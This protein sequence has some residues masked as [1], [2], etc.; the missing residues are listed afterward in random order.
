MMHARFGTT[1]FATPAQIVEREVQPL[2]GKLLAS[3]RPEAVREKFIAGKLPP[4]ET[5]ADYDASGRAV[6]GPEYTEWS[7]S[8]ENGM[9][10]RTAVEVKEAPLRLV[11]PLPGTTFLVDP[12][13]PSSGRVLLRASGPEGIHWESNSLKILETD[14]RTYVVAQEGEHRITARDPVTGQ[15]AETWIRV[16]ML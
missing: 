9:T 14:S 11:S 8:A 3:S 2:T 15:T 1:W 5:P 7:R 12:D 4:L 16:K 10:A 6:L 13:L